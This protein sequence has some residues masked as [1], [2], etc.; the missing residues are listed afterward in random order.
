VISFVIAYIESIYI[1]KSSFLET[2][3]LTQKEKSERGLGW[4]EIDFLLLS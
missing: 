2:K 1:I 4:R 3:T